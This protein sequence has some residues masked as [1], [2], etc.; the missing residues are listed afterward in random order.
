VEE[1]THPVAEPF[2]RNTSVVRVTVDLSLDG[3]AGRDVADQHFWLV[4]L[5]ISPT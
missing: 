1:T 5:G 2:S 3:V 4:L